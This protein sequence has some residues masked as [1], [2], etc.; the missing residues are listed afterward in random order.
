MGIKKMTQSKENYLRV[1]LE[2]SEVQQAIHSVDIACALGFTRA[3]VSRMLKLLSETGYV[4]KNEYGE[5]TLTDSGRAI[6]VSMKLRRSIL[7]TFLTEILGVEPPVA[8]KDACKLEH[9]IS[10]ETESKLSWHIQNYL[11]TNE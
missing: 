9:I 11:P 10:D 3:S 2:L 8:E 1:L 7:K 5:V 4:I 6:A